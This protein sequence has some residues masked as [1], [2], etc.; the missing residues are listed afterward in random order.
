MIRTETFVSIGAKFNVSDKAIVKWCKDMN[1]P[2]RKKDINT[3]T[4]ESWM[5]V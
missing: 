5:K 1:L 4:D 3:Y 2:S